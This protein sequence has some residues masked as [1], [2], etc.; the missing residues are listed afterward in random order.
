MGS[1]YV[2]WPSGLLL[3]IQISELLAEVA[4]AKD[5]KDT[6]L[7]LYLKTLREFLDS[8]P[9]EEEISVRCWHM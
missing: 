1:K 2:G 7:E 4:P 8:L 5:L 9:T 6:A 3:S